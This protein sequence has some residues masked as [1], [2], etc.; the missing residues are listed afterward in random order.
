MHSSQNSKPSTFVN[1]APHNNGGFLV[2]KLG[3]HELFLQAHW[4]DSGTIYLFTALGPKHALVFTRE[5]ADKFA[6]DKGGMVVPDLYY[7]RAP[8]NALI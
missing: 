3:V 7:D 6:A 2:E 5:E 8:H 4:Q 1:T